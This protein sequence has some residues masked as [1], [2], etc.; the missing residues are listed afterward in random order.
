MG[1]LGEKG[2]GISDSLSDSM[3]ESTNSSTSS[4][5]SSSDGSFDAKAKEYSFSS[6]GPKGWPLPKPPPAKCSKI[7]EVKPQFKDD[8]RIKLRKLGS[9]VS[10]L[11]SSF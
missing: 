10:G 5:K 4:S 9:R 2:D 8:E 11:S 3:T 7:D 6:P 1:S